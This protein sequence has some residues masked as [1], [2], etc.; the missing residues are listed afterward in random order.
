MGRSVPDEVVKCSR[1]SDLDLV[2]MATNRLFWTEVWR[3]AYGAVSREMFVGERLRTQP[4]LRPLKLELET[5]SALAS[6]YGNGR[7]D[8]APGRGSRYGH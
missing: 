8:Q 4:D 2:D 7:R 1:R 5:T 6:D 3:L